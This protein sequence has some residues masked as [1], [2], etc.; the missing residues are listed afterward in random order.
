LLQRDRVDGDVRAAVA[1]C[2][3]H[4]LEEEEL[5]SANFDYM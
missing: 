4:R 2:V 5:H 1:A 3:L